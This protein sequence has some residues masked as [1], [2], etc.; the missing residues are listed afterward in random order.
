MSNREKIIVILAGLAV[1]YGIYEYAFS[2]SPQIRKEKSGSA[3]NITEFMERMTAELKAAELSPQEKELMKKIDDT[4][5][6]KLFVSNAALADFQHISPEPLPGDLPEYTGYL[7]MG[8]RYLAIVDGM[9]YEIGDLIVKGDYELL[10]ISPK[11]IVIAG[12]G[13]KQ[14]AVPI[15]EEPEKQHSFEI[16]FE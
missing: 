9:E 5:E 8:E 16:F 6:Q 7:K 14:H 15:R 2:T 11:E 4:W 13:Q 12:H 10:R 3:E 1:L